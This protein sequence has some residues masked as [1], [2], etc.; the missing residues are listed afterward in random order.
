MS[1]YMKLFIYRESAEEEV[2]DSSCRGLGV[3]PNFRSPQRLGD[4]GG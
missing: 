2:Q 3:S 4:I 1:T